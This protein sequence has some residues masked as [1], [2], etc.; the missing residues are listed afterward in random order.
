MFSAGSLTFWGLPEPPPSPYPPPLE[1]LA[2]TSTLI[3]DLL[4]VQY[5][6]LVFITF[7]RNLS[8]CWLASFHIFLLS[9]DLRI[10]WL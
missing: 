7:F 10:Y 8:Y 5:I 4:L 1:I 9:L 2:P 6:L 3:V